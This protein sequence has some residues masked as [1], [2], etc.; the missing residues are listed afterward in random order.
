MP[1]DGFFA[2]EEP[3]DTA[4]HL[5]WLIS[6]WTASGRAHDAVQSGK[7]GEGSDG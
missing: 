7:R 1:V 2:A 4:E 3:F 5:T 6:T